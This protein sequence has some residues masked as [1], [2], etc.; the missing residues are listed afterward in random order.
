MSAGDPWLRRVPE[1]ITA[2]QVVVEDPTEEAPRLSV[3]DRLLRVQDTTHLGVYKVRFGDGRARFAV[4]LQAAEESGLLPPAA[5]D[6]GAAARAGATPRAATVG[7]PTE[8]WRYVLLLGLVVLGIEW[9]V[10][11][12]RR[13]T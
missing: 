2:E 12:R 6:I 4:N 3:S 5:L 11:S 13:T 10:W 1:D 7:G 9:F 8:I